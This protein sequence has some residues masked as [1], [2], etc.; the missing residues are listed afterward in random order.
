[1]SRSTSSRVVWTAK[2]ARD[3]AAT[4]RRH[5][6][7]G[8]VVAGADADAVAAE[9]LGDVV[10]VDAVERERDDAAA[11]LGVGGAVDGEPLDLAEAL[12]RVGGELALV[13]AHRRPCR[14]RQEVDRG[15]QADRLGDGG[16]ARL[17]LRGQLGVGGLVALDALDHVAAADPRRHRLEQLAAA[18]Q[19]ADAGRAVGLVA[20]PGVE[21]GAERLDVDRQCGTAWAPSTTTTVPAAWASRAISSSGLHVPTTF[22]TCDTATRR[23]LGAA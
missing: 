19:D 7:L 17:E 23:T 4:P 11:T 6:R 9:D 18:V 20:G 8:A 10:R 15:A 14:A 21:V 5:Q 12:E 13:G 1:M 2:V 3:V 16:G 22:D